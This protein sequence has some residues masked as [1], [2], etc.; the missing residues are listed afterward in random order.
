MQASAGGGEAQEFEDELHGQ[1]GKAEGAPR[2]R[3][4]LSR[5]FDASESR[6]ARVQGRAEEAG[7]G[8]TDGE[9]SLESPGATGTWEARR[10]RG[11]LIGFL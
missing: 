2:Q 8:G 7:R 5:Y 6:G 11:A 10:Q 9:G 1:A 4:R 3:C